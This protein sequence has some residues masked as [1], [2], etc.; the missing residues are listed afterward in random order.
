M[1]RDIDNKILR[2]LEEWQQSEGHLPQFVELYKHLLGIQTEAKA[3][4]SL[5]EPPLSQAKAIKRLNKGTPLLRWGTLFLDWALFKELFQAAIT[6][7]AECYEA[8]AVDPGPLKG[9]ASEA[10]RLREATKAWYNGQSLS[11]WAAPGPE[12]EVLAA[13]IHSA[14][15][16]FLTAQ[17]EALSELVDQE[18]WRRSYCPICGGRPDF[19]YLEKEQG[20]RWLLCSRC[21]A[22]WLFQRLECPYCGN[23][24]QDTLAYFTDDEG[25]YRLHICEQCRSYLK[26]IDLRRTEEEILLPLERLLTADMDRQGQEKGYRPGWQQPP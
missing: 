18:R 6:A 16:P 11:Q 26:V 15:A 20:G 22:Q 1:V 10:S 7:I 24:D 8:E 23:L 9:L 14:M 3:R 19:A 21:D 17:A 12:E 25:M 5:P 13:A 2:R 4:I